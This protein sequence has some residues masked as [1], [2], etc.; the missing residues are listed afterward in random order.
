VVLAVHADRQIGMI[1]ATLTEQFGRAYATEVGA[2]DFVRY[3]EAFGATGLRVE[4]LDE[5]GPAWDKA[6]AAT[7]P[8]LLE[9]RAGHGF[10]RPYPISRLSAVGD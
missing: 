6:L 5:I 8:V 9:L 3:A 7:G 4:T 2:V 1:Y 10:P